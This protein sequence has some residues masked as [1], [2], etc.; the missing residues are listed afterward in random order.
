MFEVSGDGAT[1]EPFLKTG[2]LAN[3]D[4]VVVTVVAGSADVETTYNVKLKGVTV[5][6]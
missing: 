3:L 1:Y 2:N 5:T 6:R 4:Q